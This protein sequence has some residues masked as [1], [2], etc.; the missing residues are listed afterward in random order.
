MR[1][2]CLKRK[3]INFINNNNN[4]IILTLVSADVFAWE[5]AHGE[6]ITRYGSPIGKFLPVISNNT[7]FP[8]IE[9]WFGEYRTVSSTKLK[10]TGTGL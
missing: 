7:I 4:N 8:C 1:S 3:F 5:S 6:C 10:E 9:F 2:R